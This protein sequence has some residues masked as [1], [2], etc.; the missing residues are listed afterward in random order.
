MIKRVLFFLLVYS[1]SN[2]F[3]QE[4]ASNGLLFPRMTT[5][6]RTAMPA[7][8]A[9]GIHVYDTDTK[10]LWLYNGTIWINTKTLSCLPQSMTTIQRDALPSPATGEL[11]LNT[12]EG[13]LQFYKGAIWSNCLVEDKPSSLN[14]ILANFLDSA[15]VVATN[16]TPTQHLVLDG[17][18]GNKISDG[19]GDMFDNGNFISTNFQTNIAYSNNNVVSSG[20]Y[21][22]HGKYF[23]S[24]TSGIFLM[25]ADLDVVSYLRIQGNLGADGAGTKNTLILVSGDYTAY[26]SRVFGAGSDASVN[27]MI[28]VKTNGATFQTTLAGTANNDHKLDALNVGGVNRVYYLLFSR[29]STGLIN[30]A[31]MGN[32]FDSFVEKV[33]DL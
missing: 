30:D 27:H 17:I 14:D 6:Q 8:I 31:A 4:V 29:A 21:G 33:I 16:I 5:I 32:I 15:S 13:C 11:I 9:K 18:S 20:A 1:V 10:S 26:I 2:L 28:I 24:N 19:G 23:T 7:N 3:S 25:A 12:T 22:T